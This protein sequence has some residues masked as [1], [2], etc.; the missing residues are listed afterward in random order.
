MWDGVPAGAAVVVFFIL[1]SVVGLLEGLQIAF[2]AVAKIPES[3]RVRLGVCQEDLRA[4]IQGRRS[5]PSRLYDWTAAL[6]CV[7]HVLHRSRYF[8]GCGC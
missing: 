7:V 5:Q 8:S 1:V 2:F 3:E 6:C 4:P